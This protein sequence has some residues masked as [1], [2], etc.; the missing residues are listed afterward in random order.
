LVPYLSSL[1]EED[2]RDSG[3]GETDLET[4]I[5]R[6]AHRA[7][8]AGCEGLIASGDAIRICRQAFPPPTI[9]VSPGI[10]PAG[11]AANDHK[12]HT[13]PAQAIEFGADYLV[14]GRP[15]LQAPDPKDAAQRV[16]DE[17]DQALAIR[18]TR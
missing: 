18:R 14:V 4:H 7:I 11:A 5:L 6:L 15:I 3:G 9:I 12:R 1:N 10:R 13:T 17:V 16:I 2:L 8:E